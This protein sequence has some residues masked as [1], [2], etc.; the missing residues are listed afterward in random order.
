MIN[1]ETLNLE[2]AKVLLLSVQKDIIN[3]EKNIEQIIKERDKEKELKEEAIKQKDSQLHKMLNYLVIGSIIFAGIFGIIF[4]ITSNKYGILASIACIFIMIISIVVSTYLVYIAAIGG[5]LLI[6][7]LIYG[8]WE[9]IK[10]RKALIE[11]ISTVETTKLE[12][13][14]ESKNKIFGKGNDK[15]ILVS[16]YIQSPSTVKLIQEIKTSM[17]TLLKYIKDYKETNGTTT[18]GTNGNT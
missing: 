15:G 14:E 1:I 4:L 17:P 7:L 2:E 10:N 18:N 3:T 9:V 8:I 5:L 13:S 12:M 16:S 11:T 6:G